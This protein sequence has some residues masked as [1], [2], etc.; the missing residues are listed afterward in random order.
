LASTEPGPGHYLG[1][2]SG[3]AIRGSESMWRPPVPRI[4]VPDESSSA[5]LSGFVCKD[6][7]CK[8][9]NKEW[10]REIGYI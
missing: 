10:T 1:M 6:G 4:M 9:E 2:L 3:A 5:P 8:E 7:D